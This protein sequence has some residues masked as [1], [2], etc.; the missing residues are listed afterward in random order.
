MPESGVEEMG[1]TWEGVVLKG[2]QR[3]PC[4]HETV[5]YIDCNDGYII[6]TCDNI[7]RTKYTHKLIQVKWRN[8]RL[9]DC[10]NVMY[11]IEL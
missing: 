8:I 4:V 7:A 5:L 3:D 10:T 2:Q 11:D 1:G 6:Y 9:T